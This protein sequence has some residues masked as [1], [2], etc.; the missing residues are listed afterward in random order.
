[1][2]SGK[3]QQLTVERSWSVSASIGVVLFGKSRRVGAPVIGLRGWRSQER[4]GS[5][6][7]F[8][9]SA[10]NSAVIGRAFAVLV[11]ALGVTVLAAPQ[12]TEHPLPSGALNHPSIKYFT[13]ATTDPVARLNA[14]LA[15]GSASLSFDPQNGYLRSILTALHVPIESQ[16]LVMSKTGVQ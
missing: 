11:L 1:S 16:M 15:D 7:P 2:E 13:R 3:S 9:I 14:R 10:Y 5:N 4:G 8:R 6:P 12:L